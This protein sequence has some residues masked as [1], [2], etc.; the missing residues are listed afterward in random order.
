MKEEDFEKII[1]PLIFIEKESHRKFLFEALRA[2]FNNWK[3][4]NPTPVEGDFS[5]PH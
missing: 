2:N 3:K 4:N 1:K 5:A